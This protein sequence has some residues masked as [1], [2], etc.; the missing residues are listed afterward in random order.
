MSNT[1][2]AVI[3]RGRALLANPMTSPVGLRPLLVSSRL[4]PVEYTYLRGE[5]SMRQN[6]GLT[7]SAVRPACPA[8][9]DQRSVASDPERLHTFFTRPRVTNSLASAQFELQERNSA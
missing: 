3:L 8:V 9:R 6:C 4:M 7:R 1:R 2:P 5:R